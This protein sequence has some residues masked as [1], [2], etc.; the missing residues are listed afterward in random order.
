M[1]S[2]FPVSAPRDRRSKRVGTKRL[3]SIVVQHDSEPEEIPCL[4]L[5]IS[6]DGFRL[7]TV[8]PLQAGQVVKIILP[9]ETHDALPC[10]VVWAGKEGPKRQSE[11]GLQTLGSPSFEPDQM[12][13]Y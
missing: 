2:P 11:A 9:N 8:S 4:I 6:A 12:E 5:N 1:A 7:R 13:R 10:R 3:A